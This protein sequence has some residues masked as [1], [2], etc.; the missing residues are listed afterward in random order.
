M[1]VDG[2]TTASDSFSFGDDSGEALATIKNATDSS[3]VERELLEHDHVDIG[4]RNSTGRATANAAEIGRHRTG[5]L[6]LEVGR[7]GQE[8]QVEDIHGQGDMLYSSVCIPN[9][10]VVGGLDEPPQNRRVRKDAGD[11]Y[12]ESPASNG[13]MSVTGTIA[14]ARVNHRRSWTSPSSEAPD[15]NRPRTHCRTSS[16]D[17]AGSWGSGSGGDGK[18]EAVAARGCSNTA[19]DTEQRLPI[20]SRVG[21]AAASTQVVEEEAVSKKSEEAMGADD[22]L[23]LFALALVGG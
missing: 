19:V 16:D 22:F 18:E 9:G 12:S 6:G 17:G 4:R 20:G 3:D 11:I 10:N 7:E 13:T 23:P 15:V 1:F 5:S 14:L 2:S 8:G 21:M